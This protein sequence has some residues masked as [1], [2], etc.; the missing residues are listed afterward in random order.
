MI[1]ISSLPLP[2]FPPAIILLR[3]KNV[4]FLA[5]TLH[6]SFIVS[7]RSAMITLAII[8]SVIIN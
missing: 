2:N 1:S 7:R 5:N 3:E 8:T 4:L 6:R